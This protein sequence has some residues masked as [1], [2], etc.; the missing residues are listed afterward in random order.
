MTNVYFCYYN[1]PT[2]QLPYDLCLYI[3]YTDTS[4][5]PV[6]DNQQSPV[7]IDLG[8]EEYIFIN[9]STVDASTNTISL[10]V[11]TLL[12]QEIPIVF[13]IDNIGS[14][15]SIT[16]IVDN[17]QESP[18]YLQVSDT[19]TPP[20][21]SSVVTINLTESVKKRITF[22]YT[23]TTIPPWSVTVIP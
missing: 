7:Y 17:V 3:D 11:G 13:V 9:S 12:T 10:S 8:S 1:N 16:F 18:V 22:T 14:S 6:F 2:L 23:P 15:D 21:V 4:V 19:D 5:W 20:N